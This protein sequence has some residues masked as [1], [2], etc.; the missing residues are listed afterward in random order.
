MKTLIVYYSYGH[1][2]RDIAEKLKKLLDCDMAELI[3][4]KPY[5]AVYQNLVDATENNRETRKTPEI[6]ELQVNVKEYDR[7]IIGTPVWWY[8]MAELVRTFLTQND[9][10]GKKVAVYATNAGWL[11]ST[12]RDMK[13]LIGREEIPA[14]DVKFS[15]DG[16]SMLTAETVVEHFAKEL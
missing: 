9:L 15:V 11:G 14:L 7:I 6:R 5:T 8:T 2:T 12:F 16:E 13:E 1:H 10:T 3:P 4:V